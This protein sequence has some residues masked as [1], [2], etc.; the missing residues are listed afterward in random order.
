MDDPSLLVVKEY[1]RSQHLSY[2]LSYDLLV[3]RPYVLVE[4]LKR[5][6]H[7]LHEDRCLV[8]LL[9][10][11]VTIIFHDIWVGE[12]SKQLTLLL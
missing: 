12:S 7:Q 10:H 1:Q 8:L 6:R 3:E 5:V 4:T 11:K 9:V 2:M